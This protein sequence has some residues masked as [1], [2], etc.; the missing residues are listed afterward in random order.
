MSEVWFAAFFK[1]SLIIWR[2]FKLNSQIFY[3]QN[4]EELLAAI[5]QHEDKKLCCKQSLF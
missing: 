4:V 5:F 3:Y 1:K 2:R